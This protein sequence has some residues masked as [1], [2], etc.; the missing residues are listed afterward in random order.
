MQP[1]P[2]ARQRRLL[3]AVVA[4]LLVAGVVGLASIPS[5]A[6]SPAG[7]VSNSAR[8][9][10]RTSVGA[11]RLLLVTE[12]GRLQLVVAH[13]RHGDWFGV[14]VDRPPADSAAAW[15][16]TRGGGGVP[17]L[18]AVY[19]RAQRAAAGVH[20]TWTDGRAS[21][22]VPARDGSWLVAREGHVRSRQV[23]VTDAAGAVLS[24]IKGP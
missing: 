23:T 12:G 9:T 3:G 11:A 10:A 2:T 21:D 15:A 24:D 4:V 6:S 16:A 7:T 20:V 5:G 13:R 19:G 22:I 1:T 14:P 17:P 18:S 8:I